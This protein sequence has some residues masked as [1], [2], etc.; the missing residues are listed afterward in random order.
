M[1]YFRYVAAAV[2]LTDGLTDSHGADEE[3]D[4]EGDEGAG[5]GGG[6]NEGASACFSAC[7]TPGPRTGL[8][9]RRAYYNVLLYV[10]PWVCGIHINYLAKLDVLSDF[11]LTP[12]GLENMGALAWIELIVGLAIAVSGTVYVE[13]KR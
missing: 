2:T 11:V 10:L 3:G 9:R 6:G 8:L 4:E 13:M 7:S 1:Y 12:K 5:A